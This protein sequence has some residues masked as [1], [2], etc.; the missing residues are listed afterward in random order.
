MRSR[1]YF[2]VPGNSLL[3]PPHFL[4][5]HKC[6]NI[7]FPY[8]LTVVFSQFRSQWL[9]LWRCCIWIGVGVWGCLKSCNVSLVIF[10]SFSFKNSAPN[11][12]SAADAAKNLVYG[13]GWIS[14]HWSGWGA[15]PVVSILVRNVRLIGCVH[16]LMITMRHI[17]GR[18]GSFLLNNILLLRLYVFLGNRAVGGDYSLFG[19]SL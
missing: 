5:D 13:T 15:Y 14:I 6:R 9:L 2:F 16:I 19:L 17:N 12:T 8:F 3:V 4:R 1:L 7:S 11:Y 18:W 10:S